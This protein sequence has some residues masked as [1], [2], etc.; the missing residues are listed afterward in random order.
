M[1]PILTF[2]KK[3]SLYI[4]LTIFVCI[5]LCVS[6]TYALLG[7]PVSASL[8]LKYTLIIGSIPVWYSLIKELTKG[9][10][11]VD[12]IAGVALIG[13]YIIGQYLAGV[14]VLL[15]LSGGQLFE[16]YASRRARKELSS[17]IKRTPTTAHHKDGDRIEDIPIRTVTPGMSILIKVGEIVSVDGT[18]IEGETTINES[19]LT[20][21][22]I[23]VQKRK[24]AKV[25]AG[26]ENM[27]GVIVV[28]VDKKIE[29]SRYSSI[30]RLIEQAEK[31]KAPIVRMA[32]VY[33]LYFTGIT[34]VLALIAWFV[35]YDITRVV[36][37]LVVATPCPLLLATPIAI[38]SGMSK[39]SKKGIIIKD[40]RALETL[41]KTKVF[42]F[43][44]T[45]TITLGTPE[46]AQIISLK[47]HSKDAII[48]IAASLDQLSTHVLSQA[49][50]AY[51]RQKN[52]K[53]SYPDHFEE[54]LGDGVR[55]LINGKSYLFGKQSFIE[56][57]I[58]ALK[59]SLNSFKREALKEGKLVVFLANTKTLLGVIFFQDTPRK[60]AGTLFKKL[61]KL[62]ISKL[63]MLT[64]DKKENAKPIAEM[65]HIHEVI[66]E[67]P[68]EKKLRYIRKFQKNKTL[69]AM[70]GDG[71]NDAPALSGA[72][73][74]IALGTHGQT[75]ASDTADIVILSS[76][77]ERVYDSVV[78]S[79]KTMQLAKQGIILGMGASTIAM[80]VSIGGHIQPLAGVI[81][82]EGIDVVVILNALS[83][84]RSI[85]R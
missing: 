8:V 84:G 34:F 26:T 73:V 28:T 37:V 31:S 64:G 61:G 80:I 76:S 15:M 51:T 53:L 5:S 20:G 14:V 58:P 41:A 81:L 1:I 42:V 12:V 13:T 78:I 52:L 79:K 36:A 71:I 75:A 69:V 21:E 70:I 49:L 19:T 6:L 17:L 57:H 63:V 55:G 60:E 83:L 22:N 35:S 40:G 44:K 11:G 77:I 48:S 7:E 27:Y 68:P 85:R 10:F 32:D 54:Y 33:S 16:V 43:D 25:Y 59:E 29:E 74:G 47:R 82:Q 30:I 66:S 2:I 9:S 72:D 65:F 38:V 4:F 23:P 50:L 67:C 3:Q 46:V 62:G 24:G 56:E 39:A 45:G 18:I